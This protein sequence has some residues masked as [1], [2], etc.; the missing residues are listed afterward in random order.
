[1]AAASN[2]ISNCPSLPL[3]NHPPTYLLLFFI[4]TLPVCLHSTSFYPSLHFC[5]QPLA[6]RMKWW[7]APREEERRSN[8]TPSLCISEAPSAVER[9]G[10]MQCWKRV[11][12]RG[13]CFRK[14]AVL[15]EDACWPFTVGLGHC[16]TV[17]FC[18]SLSLTLFN[19]LSSAISVVSH[20][21]R[22]AP[23][24]NCSL[25]SPLIF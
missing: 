18:L 15:P 8:L 5:Q 1:M 11:E 9:H 16:G 3:F 23:L 6:L 2:V 7:G 20:L 14:A 12:G 13:K 21:L 4:S 22:D 19:Y 25:L 10:P 24:W 17:Q